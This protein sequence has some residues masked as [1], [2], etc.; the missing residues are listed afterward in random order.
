MKIDSKIYSNVTDEKGVAK[1]KIDLP[2]DDYSAK[3][4][5]NGTGYKFTQENKY[6]IVIENPSTTLFPLTSS[7]T[8]GCAEKIFVLL[9]ASSVELSNRKVIFEV[10]GR[11]YTKI[12]NDAGIANMTIN[13]PPGTY[14]IKY[15]YLGD[16]DLYS[17]VNSS[18]LTVN[19]RIPT[20]LTVLTG[21][22]FHKNSGVTYDIKLTADKALAGKEVTVKIGSKT[23]IQSTDSN[24][25]IHLNINDLGEGTYGVEY[26][27]AGDKVYAPF[28]GYASLSVTSEIPYGYGYW[29]LY[30]NMYDLDLASLASQGTR[31]IFLHCYAVTAYGAGAVSSWANQAN[32]YGIKVHLWMQVAYDGSWHGLANRDG[33]Y[34]YDLIN[35]RVNEAKYYAGISGISGVHFDYLRFGGTAYNFPTAAES[36]N[37]FVKTAVSAIKSV[38]PNCLVS[39]A[40]MPEPDNMLYYDGQDYPTLTKYL[41]LVLPMVYKGNYHQNTAW[42][43]SI[44]KWFVDNSNGAQVWTGLQSYR[45]DDDVTRLS[46]SELSGDAQASLNGGARG[47]VMFRWGVTNFINFN[48]LKVH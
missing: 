1:F 4:F 31:H 2:S 27:F 10:N 18:K 44:T 37:Y 38:N 40:L 41:D 24:G 35:S 6:I 42:I 9:S 19:P 13:L 33:T 17:C 12:T 26:S 36:I 39:A 34:N 21:S 28:K 48:N 16:E 14:N 23:Y 5:Y 29:V 45:S 25:I 47:V 7:V 11:N 8:E 22:T 30:S 46:V 20:K 43:Q 15:Y 32:S 3:I